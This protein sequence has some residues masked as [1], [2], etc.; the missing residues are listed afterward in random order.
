L[1]LIS[2]HN[3]T[4]NEHLSGCNHISEQLLNQKQLH[5]DFADKETLH[6]L[7]KLLVFFHDIGKATLYFQ[8]RIISATMSENPE[9]LQKHRDYI[10]FF[11]QQ[12]RPTAIKQLQQN[13]NLSNHAALGA[14]L[15][16]AINPLPDEAL[17]MITLEIIK[18]HHGHLH[19]YADAEFYLDADDINFYNQQYKALLV[20]LYKP[21]LQHEGLAMP[22]NQQWEEHTLTFFKSRIKTG[23][24]LDKITKSGKVH[25]FFLQHFLF[26]LLLSADKGDVMADNKGIIQPNLYLPQQLI[27]QYKEQAFGNFTPKPI[28]LVRE[29][30]YNDIAHHVNLFAQTH[31]FFSITLPTGMGKTLSAYNAAVLMQNLLQP[32]AYRIIYCLPFTSIIDQNEAILTQIFEQQ[33]LPT[34]L[35]A[36]NHHLAP[37]TDEYNETRLSYSEAEY[38]TEGWEQEIIVTTFV[39]L[40]ES[41]FTNRNK[42]LRKFHNMTNAIV[43]LDEVQNIPPRFY[44]LIEEAFEAMAHY[45]NTKFV[46]ITATQP[47]VLTKPNNQPIELTD[48]H[49]LKTPAYF[50]AQ[51]RTRLDLSLFKQQPELGTDEL[52]QIIQAELDEKPNQSM[53]VICNTIKQAQTLFETLKAPHGNQYFLS[54]SVL[55]C[56][57]KAVIDTIKSNTAAGLPQLLVSTQVVEAGVDIDFEVVYRDFAP[58]DSINQSAGRCNRNGLMKQP[59]TVK[60]FH[61]GKARF[62]YDDTLLNITYNLLQ[63]CPDVVPETDFYQLNTAFFE[64][65]KKQVQEGNA[66]AN[67]LINLM[68]QLQLEDLSNNFQLIKNDYRSCNVFI[69]FSDEAE[70]IW[71]QYLDCHNLQNHFE[72]KRAVKQLK[73]KLL[74]FI[75][76]FP[77]DKYKPAPGYAQHEFICEPN[78]EQ[79]YSLTTGFILEPNQEA[80]MCF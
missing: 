26:S 51:N 62:I 20:N 21:I 79:Y 23:R 76:K 9:F 6:L 65:V 57:R 34:S 56:F 38:L 68:R 72:R 10:D 24:L 32:T 75:T 48:P 41:I 2:H 50:A 27:S 61:S 22:T 60:L 25:Y 52:S 7:R 16:Y 78:W 69:P 66:Q 28:D 58:L 46:F 19:N 80:V 35:I 18:R 44:P 5:P 59:G 73:P 11:I 31:H 77:K 4:L 17:K 43:L 39:Q 33:G 15:Q 40:L 8:H 36:K 14:Y 53:L 13:N 67:K 1:H 55:P 37:L 49:R 70:Q 64:S 29:Q 30:A 42:A 71:Q 12:H 45:F 54:S 63:N 47:F 74:Q 3:R